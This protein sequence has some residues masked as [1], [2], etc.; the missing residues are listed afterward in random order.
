MSACDDV[1]WKS[2]QLSTAFV[3]SYEFFYFFTKEKVTNI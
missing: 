2:M 1:S 3:F